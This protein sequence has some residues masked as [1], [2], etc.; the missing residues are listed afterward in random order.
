MEA[1]LDRS[2]FSTEDLIPL[3]IDIKNNSNSSLE[4]VDISLKQKVTYSPHK[5]SKKAH[6]EKVH[7]LDFSEEFP[8]SLKS[9]T[10]FIQFRIPPASIISPTTVQTHIIGKFLSPPVV[11]F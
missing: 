3:T 9:I 8:K 2:T 7:K 1:K 11:S 6:T 10:R 4:L 5:N